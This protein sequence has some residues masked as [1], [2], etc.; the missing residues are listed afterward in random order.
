MP[1]A[2]PP[3]DLLLERV[4]T[5][6][7]EHYTRRVTGDGRVWARSSV[8]AHLEDGEWRFGPGD[9]TWREL[10]TLPPGAR[11]ALEEAI[12]RSGVLDTAPE[13]G[14]ESAVI[15]G[16]EERWTFALDGRRTTTLLRGVP[17]VQVAAVTEVADALHEAMAAA[18]RG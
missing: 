8:A 11:A 13:H 4:L 12:R 14:P 10:V 9:D 3:G 2:D 18:D 16:S 6:G 7:E 1:E 15:G 5:R 17:E